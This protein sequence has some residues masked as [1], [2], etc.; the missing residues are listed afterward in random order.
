MHRPD[1][2]PRDPPRFSSLSLEISSHRGRS[3]QP[4]LHP[5][6]S[7]TQAFLRDNTLAAASLSMNET[8]LAGTQV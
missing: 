5:R 7:S 3:A 8:A 6:R 2:H 4:A 1:S